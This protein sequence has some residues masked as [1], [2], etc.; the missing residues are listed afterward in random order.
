MKTYHRQ[1]GVTMITM[2]AGLLLLAFFV[3]IAVTLMPVYLEHFSVSSHINR[4][5][6]DASTREMSKSEIQDTL[7]KR[8]GIDDVKNVG[9]SNI[10]ITEKPN[11]GFTID[12]EYEVRKS[13]LGNVDLLVYFHDIAETKK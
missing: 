9:P 12:C 4:I 3:L 8:F 10:T 5:S 7:L 6:K 13:F 1:Q 11:G 2:V